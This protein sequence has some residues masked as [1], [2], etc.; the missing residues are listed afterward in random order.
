MGQLK[1]AASR[2]SKWAQAA[3]GPGL[4]QTVE[5]L[6]PKST[7]PS[8]GLSASCGPRPL[9]PLSGQGTERSKPAP[10]HSSSQRSCGWLGPLST[11]TD[12]SRSASS[13]CCLITPDLNYAVFFQFFFKQLFMLTDNFPYIPPSLNY[14]LYP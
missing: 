5:R 2:P 14:F 4:H 11:E 10:T 9:F 8:E 12:H 1:A 13:L 3:H 6:P 7:H